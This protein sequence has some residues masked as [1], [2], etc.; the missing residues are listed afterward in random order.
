MS[1]NLTFLAGEKALAM[2]RDQGIRPDTIKIVA[3]AAGGPKWLVLSRLDRFL[4]SNWLAGGTER[5]YLIGSSIGAW[6]FAAACQARPLEALARFEDAYLDQTY[7]ARPDRKEIDRECARIRAK[8]LEGDAVTEILAHPTFRLNLLTVRAR[9]PASAESKPFQALGLAGAALFNAFSRK[10]SRVLFQRFLFH[11][12]RHRP[13][14]LENHGFPERLV[15]L[16]A[17]NL[18]DAILASGS[19]PL[20]MSGIRDIHGAPAGVYRDGGV[21]DYHLDLPFLNNQDGLVLFPH[22]MDRIIPG[23]FDKKM[24]WRKPSRANMDRVLLVAPSPEFIARLP[25]GRIPDR[26]DFYDYLNN[27]Q[28]RISC[29]RKAIAESERLADEFQQAVETGEIS[30]LVRPLATG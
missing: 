12:P 1:G 20:V 13:R 11:D 16:D 3:G 26:R 18:S 4:F 17:S 30:R 25:R 27:D 22:Y 28:A 19:I 24:A 7:S 29:W 2:V 5:L 15:P 14:F 21:T 10:G 23:W 8:L 9:W 6:R